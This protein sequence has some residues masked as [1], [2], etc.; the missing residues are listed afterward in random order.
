[1]P[2]SG[3][4]LLNEYATEAMSYWGFK[5]ESWRVV[6]FV[7]SGLEGVS[8]P[9]M[10]I[11]DAR[12]VLRRQPDDLTENDT[13][14]RHAFMRHLTS[15]GLP[16]PELLAQPSGHTYA[17][18]TE[19]IYELQ[20]W[21]DGQPY[22]TDGPAADT[23]LEEAA[24]TLGRLHQASADF[25]WKPHL[26]P[27]E[28]SDAAIAQAYCELIRERG[29]SG[30]LPERVGNG[31]VR[32]A[33]AA[34]V[35][36]D[37]AV[38]ALD[39][40]PGP[41]QLH[42]HG[43]YH[44]H[45]LAFGPGGVSAIY[46]LDAARWDARIAEL[47]Y[48]LL[49]FTGVRWDEQPTVTPPLVD[50]GLDVPRVQRFL[51]AYGDEAPP[52]EGEARLLADALALHFPVVFANGV[53]EDLIFTEDYDGPPNEADALARLLWADSFWLWLDRNRDTLAEAWEQA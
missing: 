46:D 16:V 25:K 45:N 21:R 13:L 52:A 4:V 27:E 23:R 12:Y 31:L 39:G 50:D 51:L 30:K 1:M 38:D 15:H 37:L 40:M 49:Y 17:V 43:D 22:V 11:A 36:L 8:R 5:P 26:W 7:T 29:Q 10:Q 48:S 44:A 32:V 42:I 6:G 14:F 3:V 53:A 19:G 41:P 2:E 34:R 35:R 28:R 9:I 47:A 20:A 24:A 33:E 18:T